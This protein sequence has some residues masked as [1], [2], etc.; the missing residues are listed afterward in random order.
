MPSRLG[1]LL[2]S[3]SEF[4]GGGWRA[5]GGFGGLWVLP[6]PQN[7]PHIRVLVSKT[8]RFLM[9]ERFCFFFL[10]GGGGGGAGLKVAGS[11]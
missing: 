6:E 4:W 8:D 10:L 9:K 7:E 3:Q 5:L 11:R 1:I 2:Q